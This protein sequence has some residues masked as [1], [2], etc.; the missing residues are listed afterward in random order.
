VMGLL[1]V[2]PKPRAGRQGTLPMQSPRDPAGRG[3][4]EMETVGEPKCTKTNPRE[5][6]RT[7]K[8][9]SGFCAI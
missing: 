3:G 4:L 1:A 7:G 8:A 6:D 2:L 9:S 5:A